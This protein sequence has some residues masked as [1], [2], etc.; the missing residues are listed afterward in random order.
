MS[1]PALPA[2]PLV[3]RSFVSLSELDDEV[4]FGIRSHLLSSGAVLI[5]GL[6]D[7]SVD[8]LA[9]FARRFAGRQLFGY[10]GGASPRRSLGPTGTY[11]ST[12]YPPALAIPLH[13]ELSYA[14]AY[15]EL[16]F[17]FCIAPPDAGGETT[18]GDGRRVLAE[19]D[20]YL[21]DEFK[22]RGIA[23]IRNLASDAGSGCSWQDAFGTEDR[24][25]VERICAGGRIEFKWLKDGSLRLE[26]QGPATTTHPLTGEE[27]WFNQAAGFYAGPAGDTSGRPRLACGFGDDGSP[28]PE[29]A[30]DHIRSVLRDNESPHRWEANDL[31]IVDNILAMHGRRPFGDLSER[32]IVLAMT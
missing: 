3:S 16:L 5:R 2:V 24:W 25:A 17:F 27:V 23:Y 32:S 8:D 9:E 12:D 10:T 19:I 22:R 21:V 4:F 18:L 15:P 26:Q 31:V 20:P 29:A 30:I 13:N 6:R 7:V 28:I 1:R 14:T 11:I